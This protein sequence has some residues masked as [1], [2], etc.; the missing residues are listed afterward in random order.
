MTKR[1]EIFIDLAES[2]SG[3]YKLEE[4]GL[5]G[6]SVTTDTISRFRLPA[7][8]IED[9]AESTIDQV[10]RSEV[11]RV[12]LAPSIV[13]ILNEEDSEDT[14]ELSELIADSR[15]LIMR[16]RRRGGSAITTEI[17]NINTNLEIEENSPY[18]GFAMELMILYDEEMDI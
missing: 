15:R 16:D 14:K 17:K 10:L 3:S 13:V 9:T 18:R 5:V 8:I 12:A 2:L 4:V 6:E 11:V 1:E 7:A